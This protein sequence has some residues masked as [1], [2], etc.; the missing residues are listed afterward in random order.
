MTKA[1]KS[2]NKP[3]GYFYYTC[4]SRGSVPAGCGGTKIASPETDKAVSMM[5]IAKHQGRPP[6]GRPHRSPRSGTR[7]GSWR[8]STKTLRT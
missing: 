2:R 8:G 7:K 4:P 1:P 6:S 3:E 5:V